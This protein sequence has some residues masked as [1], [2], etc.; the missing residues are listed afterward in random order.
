[1]KD[2]REI[3]KSLDGEEVCKYCGYSPNCPGGVSGGPN[4]PI[5]PPCAD[6]LIEDAF[7][8]DAYLADMEDADET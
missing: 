3:I 7:D 8:L 4:G 1:M 6:R 2:M 5:Y